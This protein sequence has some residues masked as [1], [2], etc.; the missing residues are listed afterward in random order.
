MRRA[1]Q[2]GAYPRRGW[3]T[4]T[5]LAAGATAREAHGHAPSHWP[6]VRTDPASVEIAT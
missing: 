5:R 3:K 4:T 1:R 2:R 6:P